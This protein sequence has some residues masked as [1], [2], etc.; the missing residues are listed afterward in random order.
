LALAFAVGIIFLYLLLPYT[1]PAELGQPLPGVFR[2]FVAFWIDFVLAMVAVAPVVGI[3]PMLTEWKRTGVFSWSF[4]RATHAPGDGLLI[5]AG[6]LLTLV[7]LVFYYALP[8]VWGKPSPGTCIAGYQVVSD[9]G[10]TLTL[11]TAVLR[12]MLG[13]I[14]ACGPYIAPFIGRD[15]KKGKF[16]LDNVFHTRAMILS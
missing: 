6:L 14:A 9:D 11:R 15:R 12:T 3:V 13:F 7:A 2:R 4:I 16:W 8:L 10:V 1:E 5:T